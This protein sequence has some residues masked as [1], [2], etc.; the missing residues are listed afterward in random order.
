MPRSVASALEE[1]SRVPGFRRPA[2]S[3]RAGSVRAARAA[4]PPRPVPAARAA[5]ARHP[6]PRPPPARRPAPPKWSSE[7]SLDWTLSMDLLDG[8]AGSHDPQRAN[9]S[10]HRGGR[11]HHGRHGRGRL[12]PAHPL[13]GDGRPGDPLR[14]QRGH[15]GGGTAGRRPDP[16]APDRPRGRPAAGARRQ[17]AGRL[18]PLRDRRGRARRPG[19][20]RVGGRLRP[21]AARRRRAAA[22]PAGATA[23]D[24]RGRRR[25]GGR[26]RAGPG[27]GPRQHG[28]A[29]AGLAGRGHPGGLR[30]LVLGA[31]PARRR[32]GRPV[33]RPHPGGRAAE[34]RGGRDQRDHAAQAGWFAAGR[35]R[36]GARPDGA[37]PGADQAPDGLGAAW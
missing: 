34:R 6:A 14:G 15:P 30:G 36:S 8:Q 37:C 1:G 10:P 17:R 19:R 26:H 22:R 13:P 29:R 9:R 21:G 23:S 24:A 35:R 28:R 11:D 5:Q 18:Q 7:L 20:G 31:G 27:R 32:S 12:Q 25:G 16:A 4:V 2:G 3:L 33:R